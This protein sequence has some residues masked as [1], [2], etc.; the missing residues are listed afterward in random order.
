MIAQ[1]LS[2]FAF[3][4]VLASQSGSGIPL[5]LQSKIIKE[6]QKQVAHS[7]VELLPFNTDSIPDSTKVISVKYLS[8]SP[9]G[10]ASMGF[11][12]RDGEGITE[13]TAKIPYRATVYAAVAMKRLK[14]GQNVTSEDYSM[15]E[16]DVTSGLYRE[17]RGLL[18]TDESKLSKMQAH[19]TLMENQ[20]IL[21]SGLIA[22][23]D[24]Q[25]GESVKLKII[26]GGLSINTM[27]IAQEPSY[28]DQPIRVISLK[29]KREVTGVLRN[30][31][32]VEVQL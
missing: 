11:V 25:R 13:L 28:L 10:M 3:Y 9:V 18:I 23:P 29:T 32:N 8:E 31:N 22:S 1:G 17:I 4:I 2:I 12:C 19:Q 20:P 30:G 14:F 21:T 26:S 24:I 5:L 15:Q 16:I 7:K 6:L 27:G